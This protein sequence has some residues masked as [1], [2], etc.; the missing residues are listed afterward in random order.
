M[1]LTSRD[2]MRNGPNDLRKIQIQMVKPDS[3]I[4]HHDILM[5]SLLQTVVL[6][7]DALFFPCQLQQNCVLSFQLTVFKSYVG[8]SR[9]VMYSFGFQQAFQRGIEP[10]D[11]V[12]FT[13]VGRHEFF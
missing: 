2:I 10:G 4:F 1:M 11:H 9:L 5:S 6:L 8:Y 12:F 3:A 13:K 7:S